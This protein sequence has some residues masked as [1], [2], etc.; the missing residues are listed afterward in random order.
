M[1]L[2][3]PIVEK[4]HKVFPDAKIDFIIRKGNEGILRGHPFLNEII[5]LDKQKNKYR[6]LFKIISQIRKS[7]Y[8]LLINLQRFGSSGFITVLSKAKHTIGFD[9][10]PFSIFFSKRVK[11]IIGKKNSNIHEID[12]NLSLIDE[13]GDKTRIMPRIYPSDNDF[14]KTES[15]NENIYICIAP[16]SVWFTKQYPTEK[17][18]GFIRIIP[19]HLNI[20]LIGSDKERELCNE[21][22][23]ES[24]RKNIYNEAGKFSI[25]ETAALMKNS[26]MNFVN[27]SAP[28]HFASAMNAPVTAIYCSTVPEFGFGPLSD[29]SRIVQTL[30]QLDCR[31]CG[32]HGFKSCPEN[33]YECAYSINSEDLLKNITN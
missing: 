13:Y 32:L 2:A 6:N 7:R 11:H 9:K 33:H 3:T 26:V 19:E 28:L 31:P 30:E 1:V 29:N 24:G 18:L 22:V 5:V 15:F 12:R 16:A 17:W 27:D 8:D 21:I 4:L 23:N 20:Y 25:L 10:N 14:K